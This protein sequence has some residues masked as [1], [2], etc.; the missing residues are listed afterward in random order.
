MFW[1]NVSSWCRYNSAVAQQTAGVSTPQPMV[2]NPNLYN[3]T[4]LGGD[5]TGIMAE[6]KWVKY[7]L[8]WCG[9][10]KY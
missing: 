6:I 5:Q 2:V 7:D 9:I 4:P 3:F 10:D 1:F 8:V